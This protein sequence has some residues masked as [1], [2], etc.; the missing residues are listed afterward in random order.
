MPQIKVDT[1]LQG[2]CVTHLR[3]LPDQSVDLIF[4]DPPYNL[5]LQHKLLR[6]NLTVVDAVDDAWDQFAT[7]ADYDTFTEAWLTE[8]RRVLKNTGT[9]WVIGSYHNI[10]R[11]GKM[12][13]D[14][15]YWTLNDIIW[16]K[17]NPTPNFRGSRFTNAT[18]TLI[19]A[20]KSEKQK[21]YTFHYHA[22][23]HLND[24]KQMRNIWRIPIC[25]GAERIKIDGKKAHS[26]QK[27]E[28]LLYRVI[29]SS[30][31]PG[32]VILDPFFGSGTTG[33]VAKRLGRHFIG[34]EREQ[35]YVDVARE[36]ISRITAQ[37]DKTVLVTPSKRHLPRVRFGS[38]VESG[39]LEIGQSLFSKDK[40]IH[41][42][43]KADGY[44]ICKHLTGSIHKVS[45][46]IQGKSSANGWD[47]WHYEDHTGTLNNIDTLRIRYR[48]DH[49][50]EQSPNGLEP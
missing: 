3:N 16:A 30:T 31:N 41:A 42:H 10:F 28:A 4:A 20:K 8:C 13:M 24:D 43:I 37:T 22:M 35:V 26:T 7:F 15:G 34:I 2:D 14:I 50:L 40:R 38:L 12:M 1:I 18:E 25:T 32:D 6:P 44:L 5:Q 29:M 45:A 36:R 9:I 21:K 33:A 11:V 19:W 48:E 39:Y 47:F 23:K 46:E 27:P 49:Q 17:N